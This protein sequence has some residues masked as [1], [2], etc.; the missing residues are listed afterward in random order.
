M[1]S[2]T[3]KGVIRLDNTYQSIAFIVITL[4]LG[5]AIL[6]TK[7][8]VMSVLGAILIGIAV[9]ATSYLMSDGSLSISL[10]AFLASSLA[11]AFGRAKWYGVGVTFLAI[12]VLIFLGFLWNAIPQFAYIGEYFDW[13]FRWWGVIAD[14][15]MAKV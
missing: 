4:I 13:L 11:V 9:F 5:G 10:T 2:F 14:L 3:V 7:N 15:I 1:C 8:K 12:V 6:W